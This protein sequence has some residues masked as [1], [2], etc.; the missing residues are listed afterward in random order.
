MKKHARR[1]GVERLE[2][3]DVPATFGTAWADPQHLTVSFAPDGT[4]ADGYS[5]G[6]FASFNALASTSVWQT[7]LLRA[8]QTWAA[9]ANLNIALVADGG[10]TVGSAGAA[11]GD[12]RFGDFR[13][14]AHAMPAVDVLAL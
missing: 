1:L 3:R 12:A 13:F 5:S 8:L 7:E 10:Q 2:A 11:Q 4:S 6:L 14:A 9:N